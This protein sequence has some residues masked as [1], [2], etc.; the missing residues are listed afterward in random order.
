MTDLE[1]D[2]FDRIDA[3]F[4]KIAELQR[5]PEENALL[6]F[7]RAAHS[8]AAIEHKLT[9]ANHEQAR[10]FAELDEKLRG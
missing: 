2:I 4:G 5:Q 6:G 3:L 10:R 7:Q 8:I 9:M 1:R